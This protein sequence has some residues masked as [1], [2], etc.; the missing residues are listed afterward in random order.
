VATSRHPPGPLGAAS[1]HGRLGIPGR[2][3][4]KGA[5]KD[6]SRGKDKARDRRRDKNR[7]RD[8]NK[9]RGRD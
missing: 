8:K 3:I 2:A 6:R 4:Q 7:G 5:H 1:R 9:D